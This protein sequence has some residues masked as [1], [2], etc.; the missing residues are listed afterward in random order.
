MANLNLRSLLEAFALGAGI[1]QSFWRTAPVHKVPVSQA[2][3][4]AKGVILKSHIEDLDVPWQGNSK[5]GQTD[6]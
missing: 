4:R 1:P 5:E 6:E 3:A 2:E